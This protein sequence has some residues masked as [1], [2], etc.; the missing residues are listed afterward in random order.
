MLSDEQIDEMERLIYFS[1]PDQ[2]MEVLS[3]LIPVLFAELR[4][5]RG[6]LS[7]KVNQFLG[8]VGHGD[9]ADAPTDGRTAQVSEE[10]VPEQPHEHT[11]DHES[12]EPQPNG[13]ASAVDLESASGGKETKGR[14]SKP[15][16]NRKKKRA[17][18]KSVDSRAVKKK[19]GRK[20]SSGKKDARRKRSEPDVGM[21]NLP[22]MR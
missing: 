5:T 6:T 16:G 14:V 2:V 22:D 20:P 19:V 10:L 4:I 21:N 9:E 3:K 1:E 12:N 15:R 7:S 8:D 17:N 11:E 18:K 13:E